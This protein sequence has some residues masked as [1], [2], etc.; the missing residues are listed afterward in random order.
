MQLRQCWV[1][2]KRSALS[3]NVHTYEYN[4]IYTKYT[5]TMTYNIT[6]KYFN[7]RAHA[8]PICMRANMAV[9]FI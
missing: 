9:L 4:I 2:T 1:P 3:A 7:S 8:I 6:Y 5:R